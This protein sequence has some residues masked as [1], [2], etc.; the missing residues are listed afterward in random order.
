MVLAVNIMVACQAFNH[1]P[2]LSF[3]L[4]I[5]NNEPGTHFVS[6]TRDM[7][8]LYNVDPN[9]IATTH[10]RINGDHYKPATQAQVDAFKAKHGIT[11]PYFLIVGGRDIFKNLQPFF[12][13]VSLLTNEEREQF[14]IVASGGG[15]FTQQYAKNMYNCFL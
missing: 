8:Y 12:Q 4:P 10:T 1:G 9:I 13:A 15:G 6:T 7:I 11:K 3:L 5:G 14:C 2:I